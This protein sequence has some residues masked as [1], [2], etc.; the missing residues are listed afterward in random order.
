M[1]AAWKAATGFIVTAAVM[2]V[3]GCGGGSTTSVTK[4]PVTPAVV[5]VPHGEV[6]GGQQPV[7]AMTM[8]LYA[9][10]TSGYGSAATDVFTHESLTLPTTNSTGGFTFPTGW[11]CI[12]TS[13]QVYLVGVGGEPFASSTPGQA[14]PNLSMMVVLGTCGNLNASTHIHINELTTVAAVW[15]LAPFMGGN[16]LAYQTIGTSSTNTTG[17]Q[18]AMN[19]AAEVVNTSTGVIPGATAPAGAT[20]PQSEVNSLADVL[21]SCINSTGG[22]PGDGS[23]CGALFTDA[24]SA[25]SGA[26]T[27]IITAAMN[28]AQNPVRNASTLWALQPG[29]PPFQ[30]YLHAAPN[31][32][33]IAIQYTGGGLNAPTSI[34][35]DQV[36]NIWVG[37]STGDVVSVFDNLGNSKAGT[38]GTV[39]GGTPGGVAIDLSGNA[40][41]TGSNNALYELTTFGPSNNNVSGGTI[42]NTYSPGGQLNLPTSIA[43][44]PSSNVWVVNSSGNSVAAFTSAGVPLA[45]SPFTGAGISAPAGIAINGNA[46]A[47]CA[48]CN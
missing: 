4:N 15:A 16:T 5:N 47:N 41:V 38:T 20:I 22:M 17:L 23:A 44:D 36:G 11:Q 40:W 33:T 43:I 48:D 1:K 8:Y 9:A 27:D 39:L 2:A 42:A 19:A 32:W 29:T 45:G 31:A 3:T 21:V 37:N 25:N 34:A 24:P 6:M 7:V 35:A 10:G 46:N 13:D 14:N 12:N 28:I 18:L 26:P 30:P